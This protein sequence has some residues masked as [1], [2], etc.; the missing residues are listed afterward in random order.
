VKYRVIYRPLADDDLIGIYSFIAD[1]NPESAIALIRK[2][3]AQCST[4]E[5]MAERAPLRER[6]GLAIRIFV[7]D[8]K[9]TVAYRIKDESIEIM[10][11]FYAGQNIPETLGD[12]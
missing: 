4:L 10:R 7:I 6:L 1:K 8:R 2:V 12:D 5:T 11:I 3:R 9:V